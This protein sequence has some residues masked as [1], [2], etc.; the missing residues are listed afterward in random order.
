MIT[1][2]IRVRF[3]LHPLKCGR[4]RI[5]RNLSKGGSIGN[6]Q[7]LLHAAYG[8]EHL[9]GGEAVHR[10]P[11][12]PCGFVSGN[13]ILEPTDRETNRRSD[14][15]TVVA[16]RVSEGETVEQGAVLV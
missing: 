13:G 3:K 1:P 10:A 6:A 11:L 2:S 8:P 4:R 7:F 5:F 9:P 16:I 14:G 12:A 15:R